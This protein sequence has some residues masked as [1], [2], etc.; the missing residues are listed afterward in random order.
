MW[1]KNCV[2]YFDLEHDNRIVENLVW[3]RL[4][5]RRIRVPGG[6]RLQGGRGGG[7]AGGAGGLCAL[8]PHLLHLRGPRPHAGGPLRARAL[9]P[10]GLRSETLRCCCCGTTTLSTNLFRSLDVY[11]SFSCSVCLVNVS[12]AYQEAVSRGCA[13]LELHVLSWNPA[14]VFYE[15]RGAVDLSD[16]DWRYYRLDEDQLRRAAVEPT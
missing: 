3:F 8:L 7:R 11:Y 6:V 9:A 16:A 12:A 14:R 10:Q 4:G 13:R 15:A 2:Q 5:A 1:I